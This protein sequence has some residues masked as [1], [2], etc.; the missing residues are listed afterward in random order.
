MTYD[1]W[2]DAAARHPDVHVE[3]CDCLPA[4]GAWV[5][6]ERVILVEQTLDRP[7]RHEVLAHELAHVD[8]DHWPTGRP[9]FDRRQE[10]QADVLAAMRLVSL[11]Q[12][13]DAIVEGA[14][15]PEDVADAVELP[16]RVV[17]RRVRVLTEAEKDYIERR[18]AAKGDVA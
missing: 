6:Q 7:H 1:P 3:P 15:G 4:N 18:L 16:A 8:L 13:A 9:W 10:R 17:R 5:P 2:R 12:L 11:E 14:L